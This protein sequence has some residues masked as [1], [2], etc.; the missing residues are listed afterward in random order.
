MTSGKPE[1]ER[2][3]VE[4]ILVA[5]I[6]EYEQSVGDLRELLSRAKRENGLVQQSSREVLR[7]VH[8][9]IRVA[10]QERGRL[11]EYRKKDGDV[12]GGR[13]LDLCAARD[14]VGRRL[15]RLRAAGG[16][17]SVSGGAE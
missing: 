2:R 8:G 11:E 10:L 7:Q 17:G 12:G 9:A 6:A 5:A 14:E 16:A 13:E 15:A 3:A 4:E 1:G